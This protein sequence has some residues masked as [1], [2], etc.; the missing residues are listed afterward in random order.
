MFYTTDNEEWSSSA[1]NGDGAVSPFFSAPFF[2]WLSSV[3]FN[4]EFWK[5]IIH[6]SLD[7]HCFYSFLK[8]MIT[9]FLAVQ[10]E[11]RFM[12]LNDFLSCANC[13]F[14]FFS[15]FFSLSLLC[16]FLFSFFF[17]LLLLLLLLLFF[18]SFCSCFG[19]FS[20]PSSSTTTII[21]TH[22]MCLVLAVCVCVSVCVSEC[23]CE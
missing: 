21:L 15:F 20:L 17:S 1:E 9:Y 19:A 6:I 16:L 5:Y 8:F 22:H 7:N 10:T 23:V 2:G 3:Y 14:L 12:I 11:Y 4:L 13:S 18:C